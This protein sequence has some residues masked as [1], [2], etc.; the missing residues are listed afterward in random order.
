MQTRLG[1]VKMK[2]LCGMPYPGRLRELRQ[3]YEQSKDGRLARPN[4]SLAL[5]NFQIERK[6]PLPETMF[7]ADGVL[8]F[9]DDGGLAPALDAFPL[10]AKRLRDALLKSAGGLPVPALLSGHD[11][12]G[13]P[14]TA[15][16]IATVPLADVGWTHSQGRL[17]GLALVW[18]RGDRRGGAGG[19]RCNSGT[20]SSDRLAAN[21]KKSSS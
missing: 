5:R 13:R 6:V 19:T 14:T 1:S 4:P 21:R 7:D 15:P 18:P 16:H 17:M 10:V 9:A 2:R 3:R 8:I 11:P 12:D 20:V